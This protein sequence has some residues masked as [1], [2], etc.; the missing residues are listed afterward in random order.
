MSNNPKFAFTKSIET[1]EAKE[2]DKEIAKFCKENGII[3]NGKSYSFRLGDVMYKVSNHK[4][5]FT[6]TKNNYT[7]YEPFKGEKPKDNVVH[8]YDATG[9]IIR[10]YKE[11]KKD[12]LERL[13]KLL[14][15]QGK[16]DSNV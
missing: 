1:K 12:Y 3:K 15:K 9:D 14:D 6:G 2:K 10:I 5:N 7:R 13:N 4:I 16:D 8:I 11:I